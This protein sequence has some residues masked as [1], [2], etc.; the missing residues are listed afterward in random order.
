MNL[1]RRLVSTPAALA[2]VTLLVA[3]SGPVALA[4]VSG[5]VYVDNGEP[6]TPPI[7]HTQVYDSWT[8]SPS[9]SLFVTHNY[10]LGGASAQY[11]ASTPYYKEEIL[12]GVAYTYLAGDDAFDPG[13]AF[14]FFSISGTP[15]GCPFVHVAT[16]DNSP[17]N[18][19]ELDHPALNFQ[20]SARLLVTAVRQDSR[21]HEHIGVWFNTARQRW[22]VFYQNTSALMEP[23]TRFL[24]LS[25]A[26]D[27]GLDF[28]PV[29]VA[30]VANTEVWNTILDDPE[31]HG[32][33]SEVILV[34][35]VWDESSGVYNDHPV[36]VSYDPS[37]GRWSLFND[38][39]TS[40]AMPIGARFFWARARVILRNDF[41]VGEI[42]V[43]FDGVVAGVP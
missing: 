7:C 3:A 6:C 9:V 22:N 32:R 33:S 29:H 26:C 34:T 43:G 24:V 12:G 14:N 15:D 13:D 20:P 41:E 17:K 35:Q 31:I 10:I 1:I 40:P 2:V 23:G 18:F 19:T 39:S 42:A 30:T 11:W 16:V 21:I 4:Q 25:D 5:Y 8:G 28:K 27:V 36:G 38:A 37:T